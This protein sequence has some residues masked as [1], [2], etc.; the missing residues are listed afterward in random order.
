MTDFIY[1]K[2][3]HLCLRRDTAYISTIYSTE[4]V[5]VEVEKE[6][7]VRKHP[8]FWQKEKRTKIVTEEVTSYHFYYGDGNGEAGTKCH[9]TDFDDLFKK[10]KFIAELLQKKTK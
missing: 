3:R 9:D 2:E 10:W 8:F 7:E 1:N 4:K 6:V 5:E